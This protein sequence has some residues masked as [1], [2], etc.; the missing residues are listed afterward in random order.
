M[1]TSDFPSCGLPGLNG[2]ISDKSLNSYTVD[3]D[4]G[5][6]HGELEQSLTYMLENQ[7]TQLYISEKDFIET[8]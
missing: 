1:I 2:K 8:L 7:E 4:S 5:P 3:K 6:L